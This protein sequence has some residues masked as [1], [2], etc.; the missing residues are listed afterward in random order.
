M[1]GPSTW[2]SVTHRGDLEETPGSW[3]QPGSALVIATILE[4]NQ[5]KKDV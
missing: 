5:K 2:D 3:S 1:N 4:M